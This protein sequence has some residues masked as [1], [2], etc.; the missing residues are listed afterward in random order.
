MSE[1]KHFD[2][3]KKKKKVNHVLETFSGTPLLSKAHVVNR[4]NLEK[5]YIS[6]LT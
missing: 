2:H 3:L 1:N 5:P 4:V 6:N